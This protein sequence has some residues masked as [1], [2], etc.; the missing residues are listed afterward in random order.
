MPGKYGWTREVVELSAHHWIEYNSL[1]RTLNMM[2]FK[3]FSVKAVRDAMRVTLENLPMNIPFDVN[4]R[5][6]DDAI[7]LDLNHSVP[8]NL[9]R[10]MVTALD[11]SDRDNEKGRHEPDAQR[12]RAYSNLE[13]AKV[14]FYQALY[15]FLDLLGSLPADSAYVVGAYTQ[16]S[17]EKQF[18]LTWTPSA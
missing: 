6:P 5:F 10:Q 13:D 14:A 12:L 1:M 9:M 17:F 3:S 16:L 15:A 8:N 11:L 2:K 18:R 7:Y 4:N